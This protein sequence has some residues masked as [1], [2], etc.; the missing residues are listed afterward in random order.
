MEEKQHAKMR[1]PTSEKI[2]SFFDVPFSSGNKQILQ[3]I[4]RK[5]RAL[6]VEPL[7]VFLDFRIFKL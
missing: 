2:G 7:G 4:R 5:R 6:L 1:G 3:S